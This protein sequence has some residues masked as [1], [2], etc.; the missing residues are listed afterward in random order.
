[1]F[2]RLV[3]VVLHKISIS[4]LFSIF[5][6][7]I[8]SI[9]S[10]ALLV[11]PMSF[12]F[13]LLQVLF[14]KNSLSYLLVCAIVSFTCIICY[15]RRKYYRVA[16]KLKGPFQWPL[17]G[18]GSIFTL[19]VSVMHEQHFYFRWERTIRVFCRDSWLAR[20]ENMIQKELSLTVR[21]PKRHLSNSF[22]RYWLAISKYT[23]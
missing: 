6:L 7:C 12:L 21:I 1:M 9:V 10:S 5:E 4:S 20:S 11:S 23:L 19:K 22:D 13:P 15:R 18:A 17:L 14:Q 8:S 16:G 3:S 2:L